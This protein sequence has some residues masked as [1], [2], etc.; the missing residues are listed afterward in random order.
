[1]FIAGADL[2]ELEFVELFN[3]NPFFEDLSGFRLS[4]AI[5]FAFPNGTV[6]PIRNIG[7]GVVTV[8]RG[9][10][11]ALRLAGVMMGTE[12]RLLRRHQT[13]AMAQNWRYLRSCSEN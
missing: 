11:V 13:R 10:G 1:M 4:G 5:E 2:K 6:L 3:S 8:T 9:S 12:Y 7:A